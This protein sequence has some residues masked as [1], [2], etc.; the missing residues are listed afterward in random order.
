MERLFVK[1][2]APLFNTT[3]RFVLGPIPDDLMTSFLRRAR[4]REARRWRWKRRGGREPGWPVPDDL[5]RLAYETFE[6]TPGDSIGK[7]EVAAGLC[8][9]VGRLESFY[10]TST[11]CSVRSATC[12]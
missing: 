6:L 9:A 3:E 7:D 12:A 1:H 8:R 4:R 2:N 10:R 11:A 5:R